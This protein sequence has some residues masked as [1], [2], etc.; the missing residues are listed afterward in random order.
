MPFISLLYR[1]DLD[2]SD[3]VA[4]ILFFFFEVLCYKML[5]IWIGISY[6][7]SED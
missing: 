1:K 5:D 2:N 7:H 3:G 6:E 4:L